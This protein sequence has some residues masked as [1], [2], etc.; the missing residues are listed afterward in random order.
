MSIVVVSAN[1][2]WPITLLNDYFQVDTGNLNSWSVEVCYQ[3]ATL[4]VENFSISNLAIYPNPNNQNVLGVSL[5]KEATEGNINMFN[6][7]GQLISAQAIVAENGTKQFNLNIEQLGTG[8]YFIE[9]YFNGKK[10][11][12]RLVKL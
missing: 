7:Q 9:F 10:E 5:N 11:V 8:V 12:K 6:L 2:L 3:Q 1:R 4:S